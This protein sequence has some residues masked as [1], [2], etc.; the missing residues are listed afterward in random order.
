MTDSVQIWKP[1]FRILD[2]SGDPIAGGKI[3]FF[4][5]GTSTPRTVYTDKGLTA[6]ATTVITADSSGVP[7]VS[8]TDVVAYTNTSDYK[9]VITDAD[10]AVVITVDNLAGALDTSGYLTTASPLSIPVQSKTSGYTILA[11]DLGNKIVCDAS[12]GA[13]TITL[14]AAATA[15][16]GATICIEKSESSSNIVT[17]DGN[18]TETI[19]GLQTIS[20]SR[21]DSSVLLTCDGSNW[22]I[23]ASHKYGAGQN[24]IVAQD[25]SYRTLSTAMVL[26]DS[27]PTS[28]EGDVIDTVSITPSTSSAQVEIEIDFFFVADANEVAA[29]A[30]FKNSDAAA[31][32]A[33]CQEA[34]N[35]EYQHFHAKAVVS[36]ATSASV[37]YTLR[38]GPTT[39]ANNLDLLG[40][41]S[42]RL[43]GGVATS[44]MIA[45]EI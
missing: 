12:G 19:D 37:T 32:W 22:H 15:G 10:D 11:S 18:S 41:T 44:T 31:V 45:K 43:F 14:I 29:F 4:D 21:A 30:L 2:D 33:T 38:G 36:P 17:V 5:A 28:S 9:V 6:N 40:T 24:E 26:D 25:A 42:A 35:G 8:S 23:V 7:Q 16:D 3:K 27:I 1:G 39:G 20:L 34:N 13:F